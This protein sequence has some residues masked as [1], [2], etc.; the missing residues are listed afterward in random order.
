MGKFVTR[1][2]EQVKW[3]SC[4]RI[5]KRGHSGILRSLQILSWFTSSALA[6]KIIRLEQRFIIW[7]PPCLANVIVYTNC[8]SPFPWKLKVQVE[9]PSGFTVEILWLSQSEKNAR[10]GLEHE[11]FWLPFRCLMTK[12]SCWH[13]HTFAP[14]LHPIQVGRYISY[15]FMLPDVVLDPH[16]VTTVTAWENAQPYRGRTTVSMVYW[17][18]LF[19][20]HCNMNVYLIDNGRRGLPRLF[21]AFGPSV[22]LSF[23]AFLSLISICLK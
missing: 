7:K 4:S 8:C 9:L 12:L 23:N 2:K 13:C 3:H 17:S 18:K 10:Q 14:S 20:R 1:H 6:I 15:R 21:R 22:Q 16:W 5:F 19:G 11:I